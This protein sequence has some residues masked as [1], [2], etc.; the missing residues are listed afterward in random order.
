[1]EQKHLKECGSHPDSKHYHQPCSCMEQELK[2]HRE[3][4]KEIFSKM[5]LKDFKRN[6]D[7]LSALYQTENYLIKK[8]L[9][10]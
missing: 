10:N 5:S 9:T 6:L 7:F 8:I 4:M 3:Y 1:M 2:K